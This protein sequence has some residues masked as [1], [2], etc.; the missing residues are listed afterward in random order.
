MVYAPDTYNFNL[1]NNIVVNFSR[2]PI[3][4]RLTSN[5]IASFQY[6]RV[7]DPA[8]IGTRRNDIIV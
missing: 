3:K 4:I 5:S 2:K 1:L 7:R 8:H 6:I